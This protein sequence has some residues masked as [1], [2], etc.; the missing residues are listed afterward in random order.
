MSVTSLSTGRGLLVNLSL[1]LGLNALR[2]S[3]RR[4]PRVMIDVGPIVECVDVTP[5]DYAAAHSQERIVEAKVRLSV[6]LEAGREAELEQLQVTIGSPERRMRVVDFQPRTEL[7]SELAGDVEVC[8]STDTVQSLNASLGGPAAVPQPVPAQ[9]AP[10]AGVGMTQNRGIKETYHRLSPKQA[11][12]ASGT[13]NAEHGVFFKWR[14]SSQAAL[15]VARSN[16]AAFG[17]P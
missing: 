2:P 11:V 10:G 15:R 9:A 8:N 3:L 13:T 6:M 4:A 1:L 7:V 16:A 12:L 17:A 5:H 14:R